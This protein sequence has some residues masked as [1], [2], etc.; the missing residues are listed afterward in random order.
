MDKVL[1]EIDDLDSLETEE[2][3]RKQIDEDLKTADDEREKSPRD[4]PE[5]QRQLLEQRIKALETELMAVDGATP[6]IVNKMQKTFLASPA[7]SP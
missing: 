2:I 6:K 5:Y 7:P 1:R 4:L 3:L